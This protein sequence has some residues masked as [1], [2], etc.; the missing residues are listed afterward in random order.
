MGTDLYASSSEIVSHALLD[1]MDPID[2]IDE[3][4]QRNQ[5]DQMLVVDFST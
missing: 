2:Q 1:Q 3:I 5:T 4:D